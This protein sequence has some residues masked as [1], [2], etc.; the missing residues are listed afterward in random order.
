MTEIRCNHITC[1]NNKK[2]RC[3][4][5]NPRNNKDAI[6]F[7]SAIVEGLTEGGIIREGKI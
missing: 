7:V 5:N 2:C 4:D 3:Y 1:L 6:N